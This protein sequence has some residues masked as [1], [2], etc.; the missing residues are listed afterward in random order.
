MRMRQSL[1]LAVSCAWFGMS[2]PICAAAPAACAAIGEKAAPQPDEL[3]GTVSMTYR[4]ASGRA[5]RL[6]VRPATAAGGAPH[7]APAIVLFF[8]GGWLYGSIRQFDGQAQALAAAGITTILADYRVLCRDGTGPPAAMQDAAAAMRFVR[9][10]ATSLGIDPH[11]LAAGGGGAA[12]GQLALSTAF[13]PD[14]LARPNALVLFNPVVD[15]RMGGLA[16]HFEHFP[17][18]AVRAASPIMHASI[19]YPPML[20]MHG[21]DDPLMP[22][23]KVQDFCDAVAARGHA[24]ELLAYAGARHGFF[25]QTVASGRWFT[26]TRDAMVAFLKR[27]L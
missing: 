22:I 3:P 8:G 11:R 25:N 14:P 20:I 15:L 2:A 18:S 9:V 7:A 24:C 4:Y 21:T 12:G 6:H 1:L 16:R 23:G 10:R 26:A 13:G 5:L 19:A 27:S 17:P